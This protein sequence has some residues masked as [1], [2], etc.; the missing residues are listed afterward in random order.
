M[1]TKREKEAVERLWTHPVNYQWSTRNA[2]AT[3]SVH[4]VPSGYLARCNGRRALSR[5]SLI[6]AAERC[7]RKV[8][9]LENNRRARAYIADF[10]AT[11][12]KLTHWS[13][14]DTWATAVVEWP[15]P[16]LPATGRWAA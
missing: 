6:E 2:R 3:V 14:R 5:V 13:C 4:R 10:S 11:G 15:K 9:G 7:A 12:I 16:L 8:A 1:K